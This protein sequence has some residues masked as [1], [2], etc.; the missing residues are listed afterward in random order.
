MFNHFQFQD[1]VCRSAIGIANLLAERDDVEVT[2]IPI[3]KFEKKTRGFLSPKVKLK[4]IFGVYFRGFSKIASL[5]PEKWIYNKYIKGQYNIEIAFQFGTSYHIITACEKPKGVKRIGWIHG[6]DNSYKK[7]YIKM[8]QMVCVSQSN[9]IRAFHDLDGQV[10]VTYNYN[11][12]DDD[13]VREQGKES[14][15]LG[16]K[17]AE[18]KFVTVGRLSPE[19]GYARLISIMARL[20]DNGYKFTLWIL[21]SGP[22]ESL[23]RK[24]VTARQLEDHVI[25]TGAKKNP[26]AYTSK[27]DI[28]ICSSF[29]EGYSTACTEAVMLGVP[30]ITTNV[31]GGEEIIKDAECGILTQMDDE[32][33]YQGIK[34][35]LDNPKIIGEWKKTLQQTRER[36]SARNRFEQLKR[37]LAIK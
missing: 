32:S 15:N 13:K 19:K 29:S 35:V 23:L 6:Y 27:A 12:I 9:A 30:V 1:G 36:F 14:I 34:Q 26:H 7:Y 16:I 11:P 8:D 31:S 22:Q 20:R 28:F 2:L 4:K 5:I 33:L 21:G 18:V 3:Y 24:E 10:P 25:L 17:N 37:I